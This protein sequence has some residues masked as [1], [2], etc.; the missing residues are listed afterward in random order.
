MLREIEVAVSKTVVTTKTVTV[1]LPETDTYYAWNDDDLFFSEGLVL[2]AILLKYEKSSNYYLVQI[3]RNKQD[4][5][6]FHPTDC[7]DNYFL[8][9]KGLR[10]RALDILTKKNDDFK[11]ITKEEFDHKRFELLNEFKKR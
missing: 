10:N 2:F 8:D 6:D 5:T 7:K 4:F 11:P 1:D 3:S 9:Y